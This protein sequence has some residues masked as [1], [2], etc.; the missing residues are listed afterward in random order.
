MHNITTK[1]K[2]L[3]LITKSNWGGAQRYVFDLATNLDPE[4]FE[5]VVALGG[6]GE[7]ASKLEEH[8]IKVVRLAHM[9]N[10]LSAFTLI[11]IINE[12]AQ[13]L[14]KEHPDVLHANSSI[15]GFAGTL[16]GRCV[17]V[18][19]ILFT[20]HGWAFNEDRSQLQKNFFKTFHWL[21]V[22]LSHCTIAVSTATKSQMSWPWAQDKMTIINPGRTIKD[23][24][25]RS[26]ARGILETKII[27]SEGNLSDYHTDVWVGTIAELHPIKQLNRAI[28][29]LA[30]LSRTMPNIRYIII[31]DGQCKKQLQQQVTDL[32]LEQHVYFTNSIHEAGRFIPAFDVFVLPSQSEAFGYVLLEAGI[33]GVP[34]V[35]TDTGGIPDI[36]T[37]NETGLLIPV[38]D[39]PALTNALQTLLT[40]KALRKKLADEN[41]T[42]ADTRTVEKMTEETVGVYLK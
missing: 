4:Q 10:S 25:S 35:A 13:L 22:L 36:I 31:G 8:N 27:D 7:L 2:V 12:C 5:V 3:F 14:R 21:T 17:R 32:G 40:D 16:A 34:V 15:A 11:K 20:A 26:E 41:K 23:F 24:K 42:N 19:R 33:A 1:K 37:H 29:S 6:N 9:Q 38:N 30:S 28:D 18:Q 39:T